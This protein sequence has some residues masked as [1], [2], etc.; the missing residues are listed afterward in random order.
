MDATVIE[1]DDNEDEIASAYLTLEWDGNKL[2]DFK[3]AYD[4]VK[5]TIIIK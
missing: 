4:S 3:I 5:G 1:K 2:R